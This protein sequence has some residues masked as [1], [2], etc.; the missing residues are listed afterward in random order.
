MHTLEQLR[1]GELAGI[2][3]LQ[4]RCG[5]TEFPREIFDLA[6]SLEIL[7]LS[8]N[9][10]SALPDDLPRLH[11][12]RV[13]FCS[14]NPFTELPEVLGQCSQ[15]SMV[16][17]KANRIAHV[18]PKALPPLLRWLILTDNAL[19]ELPAEI[20]NCEHM[21]KL[22]LAGNQLQSL[23]PELAKCT[24]LELMRISANQLTEFPQ[25]LLGMSRLTW[26][27][28]AGNPFCENL[29]S[30]AI[31][32]A[33]MQCIKWPQLQLQHQL[34]EG[35]SG[36]IHQAVLRTDTGEEAVAVKLFKGEVTS[37]GLPDCEM[38]A[39]MHAGAHPH[40][41]SAMARVIEH[42]N[43]QQALVMPLVAP[44]FGN[45]AGPPS[46]ESCTRD[47][48]APSQRFSWP[49]TLRMAKGIA[50]AA[51]HLHA[52][53]IL[54]GDLYAHNILHTAQGDALLSDF[55]AAAFFDVNDA[56]MAQGLE[57]LEVR[58]LGC[59][60]EE[61]A[62]QC[63]ATIKDATQHQA[64]ALLSQQCLQET[65]LNRPSLAQICTKLEAL[66]K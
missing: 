12:L 34:G 10:L 38:A 65:P 58:A 9:Q 50:S 22:A 64:L 28:Y 39:C 35:A 44:E 46:L 37:D 23:P 47:V 6:D 3:R 59:L 62:M 55:G 7:D 1:N 45:L 43:H 66:S 53:G 17:F 41:V 40:L 2:Q 56:A 19:T 49:A 51:Q 60:L 25:W 36:V 32:N 52:R 29:E 57:K 48:Y 14:D 13:I 20:G 15:L 26:L 16:G 63:D 21:Q 11:K 5:L 30:E 27:A 31:A 61:L 54:H 24:R 18:S 42:P 33:P 8:G 4:L